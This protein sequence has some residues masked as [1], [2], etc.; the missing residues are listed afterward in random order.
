MG[1]CV[2]KCG[3]HT[4]GMRIER[5]AGQRHAHMYVHTSFSSFASVMPAAICLVVRLPCA[6]CASQSTLCSC[7][8]TCAAVCVHKS[9][10]VLTVEAGMLAVDA[11]F[12]LKQRVCNMGT[13]GDK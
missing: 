5:H 10:L 7:S 3:T 1:Q 4:R 11:G 12:F 8:T 9:A 6:D 13:I 2:S